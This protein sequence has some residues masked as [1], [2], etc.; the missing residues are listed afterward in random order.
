MWPKTAGKKEGES[1]KA[2]RSI[3]VH[4]AGVCIRGSKVLS[5]L[6]SLIDNYLID[7]KKKS[8]TEIAVGQL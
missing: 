7:S 6:P 4:L 2:G 1:T 3:V 5:L 8:K